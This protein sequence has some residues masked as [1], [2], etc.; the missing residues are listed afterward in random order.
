MI[1]IKRVVR[2]SH[3]VPLS[4]LKERAGVVLDAADEHGK[5]AGVHADRELSQLPE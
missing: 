5:L 4:L 3:V 1:E 2:D